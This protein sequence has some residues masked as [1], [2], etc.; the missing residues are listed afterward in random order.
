MLFI[1]T[2]AQMTEIY[3]PTNLGEKKKK[4]TPRALL[5][6]TLIYKHHSKI[7]HNLRHIHQLP[8]HT[9]HTTILLLD[10]VVSY[11]ETPFIQQLPFQDQLTAVQ[12]QLETLSIGP[13][14]EQGFEEDCTEED[15]A[16]ETG[17]E[18]DNGVA[19]QDMLVDL[20]GQ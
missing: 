2:L 8:S 20:V 3:I 14:Q 18:H 1:F 7:A 12:G 4:I 5:T 19:H 6:T 11:N 9:N 10:T 15:H 17:V 16:I 13:A